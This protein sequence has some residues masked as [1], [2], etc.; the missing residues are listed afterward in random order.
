MGRGLNLWRSIFIDT[1]FRF[2]LLSFFL[3][4]PEVLQ[5]FACPTAHTPLQQGM[6]VEL[7]RNLHLKQA[8]RTNDWSDEDMEEYEEC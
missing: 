4:F 1:A 3:D 8:P 2:T 5:P 6:T 7:S